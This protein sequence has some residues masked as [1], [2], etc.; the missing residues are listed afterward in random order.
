MPAAA[1]SGQ[2]VCLPIRQQKHLFSS[3]GNEFFSAFPPPRGPLGFSS[4]SPPI[5]EGPQITLCSTRAPF[6][7]FLIA[8]SL[9]DSGADERRAGVGE[10]RPWC[11][12]LLKDVS[13]LS[14]Q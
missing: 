10:A 11:S 6:T 4:N 7:L 1:L 8:G 14:V 9:N 13:F 3:G 5:L 2:E 12:P